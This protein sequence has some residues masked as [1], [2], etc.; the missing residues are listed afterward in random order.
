MATASRLIIDSTLTDWANE[1]ESRNMVFLNV[2]LA[3]SVVSAESRLLERLIDRPLSY[4]LDFI[5]SLSGAKR[6][7]KLV[8]E[9]DLATTGPLGETV[10]VIQLAANFAEAVSSCV[11]S[12]R[13]WKSSCSKPLSTGEG[14]R[15]DS[16]LV[17]EDHRARLHLPF[18]GG[19]A[20]IQS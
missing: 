10:Y 4:T 19:E 15:L 20:Q 17:L 8:R 18:E 3:C 6:F 1:L 16:A 9:L 7:M 2:A 12:T 13:G 14:A 5:L 11:K